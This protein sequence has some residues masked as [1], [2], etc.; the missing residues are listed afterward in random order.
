MTPDRAFILIGFYKP[1]P[2]TSEGGEEGCKRLVLGISN[3]R[4]N[5]DG[6]SQTC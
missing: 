5:I 1:K 4:E 6:G 3:W 2:N